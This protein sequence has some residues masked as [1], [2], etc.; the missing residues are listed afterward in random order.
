MTNDKLVKR[1]FNSFLFISI[2]S[3]ITATAGALVDGI[4]IGQMLGQQSFSA[5][6][7]S[8]PLVILSAAIAGV[9]SNGGSASC[10]IHMGRGDDHAV[11]LNFTVTCAGAFAA[12]VLLT[13]AMLLF[14]E[15]IA[16][17][18]GAEG[19]LVPLTANYIRGLGVGMIPT[20][21][22]QVI[23][24]YI[25]LNDGMHISFLSVIVM[26]TVN[27]GLDIFFAMVLQ[28]GMFGMGLATSISYLAAMLTCC[29][30]FLRKSNIFKFTHSV[31]G[32][33]E[34][35]Q[36]IA[37]GIPSALNRACITVRSIAFNRL[38]L[39][40]GGSVAVS[41]LAT[42]NNVNQIFSSITMGVGMTATMLAGIFFGER[43]DKML[44]KT[45]RVSVRTGLMLST[46]CSVLVIIFAEPVVSI[47]IKDN[48]EALAL[49]TRSLR[50]FCLSLPLSLICVVLINF[51]QCTKNLF[52]ANLICIT[53]GLVFVLAIAFSLSPVMGTDAVWIS[54]LCAE[55]L[56]LGV[57]AVMIRIKSGKWPV[58]WRNLSMPA[59]DLIVDSERILDLSLN[60]SMEQ[61][62]KL[63]ARIHEFCSMYT[64]DHKKVGHLALCIEEMAGN[65]IQYGRKGTKPLTMDIRIIMEH[66]GISFR[67]RDDGIPFNPIQYD[68]EH[69][70]AIGETMGIRLV[71]GIAKEFQYTNA[72]GMNNLLI[73]L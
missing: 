34:F 1:I 60:G 25:R 39:V 9:F 52:M 59:K 41:A 13:A 46:I 61:V 24:I 36:V 42:Q 11:R 4:V 7:L 2:L 17:L 16:M 8:S 54:F 47:Y 15:Q 35:A 45:L 19:S 30:H 37:M 63:S 66:D 53:H 65:I 20:V 57:V 48:A 44:E 55:V 23:M 40:L 43:D 73:K 28:L 69:Q 51:Y 3:L 5:F 50:F 70:S 58:N 12:A 62:M 29:T 33:K 38:L 67:I 68:D 49:A 64:N 22:T 56:T 31:K 72:I 6:G 71:R 18:L 14:S 32:G 27:I 21:M 26:T 10:S